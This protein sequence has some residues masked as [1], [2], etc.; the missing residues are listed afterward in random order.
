MTTH[1]GAI[2]DAR[3]DLML[4]DLEAHHEAGDHAERPIAD[5]RWCEDEAADAI[6]EHA[7]MGRAVRAGAA[8]PYKPADSWTTDAEGY[9]V[10]GVA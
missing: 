1:A 9:V 8:N 6:A 3:E 5:C 2:Q 4:A 10:R 7:W